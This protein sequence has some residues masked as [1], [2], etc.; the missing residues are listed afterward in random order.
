ML[1]EL[2]RFV[3]QI[4][5]SGTHAEEQVKHEMLIRPQSFRLQYQKWLRQGRH[6]EFLKNLY[7]SFTL[8]K[9]GVDGE[10]PLHYFSDLQRKHLLLHYMDSMGRDLLPFLLDYFKDSS[11]KLGYQV[12][13][14]DRKVVEHLGYIEK[15]EKHV[16]KPVVAPF[17]PA[18]RREQLYGII[19][20]QIRYVDERP[21]FLELSAE[22]IKSSKFHPAFSFDEY[23]E[24]LLAC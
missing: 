4:F 22:E 20:I 17:P 10:I 7:T 1:S 18:G 6:K 24:I 21:L 8:N 5:R 13:L 14:S 11:V 15:V 19:A 23:I 3:R 9:L 16:L 2:A 12:Y